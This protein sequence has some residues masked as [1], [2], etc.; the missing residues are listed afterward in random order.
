[1]YNSQQDLLTAV[2]AIPG[3]I[4]VVKTEPLETLGTIERVRFTIGYEPV[5]NS[6]TLD[7]YSN[8]YSR[9]TDQNAT[10]YNKYKLLKPLPATFRTQVS[11]FDTVKNSLEAYLKANFDGYFIDLDKINSTELFATAIVYSTGQAGNTTENRIFVWH[12]GTTVVHEVIG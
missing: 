3:F 9:E 6:G 8:V 7:F 5:A 2:Q 12:N 11:N 10:D 4:K 1:M